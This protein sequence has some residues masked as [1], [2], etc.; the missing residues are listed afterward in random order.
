MSKNK[1]FIASTLEQL[2]ES[3]EELKQRSQSEGTRAIA[4]VFSA[5]G[6]P[7]GIL[8]CVPVPTTSNTLLLLWQHFQFMR[9]T[10]RWIHLRSNDRHE[11]ISHSPADPFLTLRWLSGLGQGKDTPVHVGSLSERGNP[12]LWSHHKRCP[13]QSLIPQAHCH[14]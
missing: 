2:T 9:E 12:A 3:Q 14:Y 13:L 6:A 1:K 4:C 7:S 11:S 8:P 10:N 5:R